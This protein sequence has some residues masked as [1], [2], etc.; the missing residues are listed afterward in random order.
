MKEDMKKTLCELQERAIK[1][2]KKLLEK[3]DISPTEWKAAGDAVDIIKDVEKS[4]KDA[5]T[6]AAMEEEYGDP[7]DM[8][9]SERGMNYGRNY[10]GGY[11]PMNDSFA[12]RRPG[13]RTNMAG[14]NHYPRS[15]YGGT[16]Y[17]EGP[18]NTITNLRNLMNNAS[19]ESERMMYQRFIDEA[20]R[21]R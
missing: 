12:G 10:R 8:G 19:S 6:S 20:E 3:P 18:D 15:S 13:M 9:E 2:I 5:L 7:F 14:N 16:N 17:S 11:Y 21:M 4:I 1:D